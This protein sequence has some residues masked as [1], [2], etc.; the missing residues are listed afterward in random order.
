[1]QLRIPL[2][3]RLPPRAEE[4]VPGRMDHQRARESD[5]HGAERRP[6]AGQQAAPTPP[7]RRH[8]D[9]QPTRLSRAGVV[10]GCSAN[11]RSAAADLGC[12]SGGNEARSSGVR[13]P[14]P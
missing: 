2:L 7:R 1:M 6:E 10:Y 11:Q 5:A 4:A 3:R 13:P 8:R 14:S 12:G 9:G